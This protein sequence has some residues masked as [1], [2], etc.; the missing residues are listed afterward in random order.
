[1]YCG[2]SLLAVQLY[3]CPKH[4]HAPRTTQDGPVQIW[5][6]GYSRSCSR[7]KTSHL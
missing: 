6:K 4:V 5:V 1:M 7:C 2:P 3:A